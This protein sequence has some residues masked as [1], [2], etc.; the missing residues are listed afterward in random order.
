MTPPVPSTSFKS[1]IA[2]ADSYQSES[3][4]HDARRHDLE[5]G[6]LDAVEHFG[7]L[8]G[9]PADQ[10][11]GWLRAIAGRHVVQMRC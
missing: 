6:H 4:N 1:A 8:C 7:R 9:V 3:A 2:F 5:A 10:T 11:A